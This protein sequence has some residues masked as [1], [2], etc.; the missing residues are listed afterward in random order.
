DVVRKNINDLGGHVQIRSEANKGT[1]LT[2]RLPLTLAILEGQLVRI[3][4]EIYVVP[5]TSIVESLQVEP[6]RVSSIARRAELYK[7]R[8]EYI[9]IVRLA[10]AFHGHSHELDEG[11]LV[12]VEAD[13]HRVGLAVEEMLGQQQVVIKSLETNYQPIKGVSGATILGDG[14]VALILDIPGLLQ[15]CVDRSLTQIAA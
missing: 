11:Q 6:T 14:R 13:N 2:I 15:G 1:I 12:V 7:L 4:T 9:S 10:Q 3:G 5:L 8:D